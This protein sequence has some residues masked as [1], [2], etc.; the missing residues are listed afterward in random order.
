MEV[1]IVQ[2]EEDIIIGGFLIKSTGENFN[3][4]I[5]VLY[6]DFINNGKMEL[7]N[8]ISKNNHE[9]YEVTWYQSDKEGFKWLLGQK[10]NKAD[11]LDTKIIK[12]GDY[13]VS[14]FPPKYDKIKAW[15]DLWSEGIPGIGYKAIEE[16]NVNIAFMYYPKGLDGENEIWALVEKV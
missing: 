14:K 5:E 7:L 11:G 8:N 6:N 10:I 2:I 15:E 3:K 1:K 13:A 12:K 9:Y 4:D 16:D